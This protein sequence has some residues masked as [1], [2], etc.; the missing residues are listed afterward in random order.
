MQPGLSRPPD[1]R[2]AL[3]ELA[4]WD[5]N[6]RH[7]I[8]AVLTAAGKIRDALAEHAA[9]D[10]WLSRTRDDPNISV[11]EGNVWHQRDFD[12]SAALGNAED[13]LVAAL[14]ALA[15]PIEPTYRSRAEMEPLFAGPQREAPYPPGIVEP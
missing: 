3:S 12:A 2:T 5:S 9:C 15:E 13:E 8:G 1:P 14:A 10:E 7:E 6:A 4:A 11:K